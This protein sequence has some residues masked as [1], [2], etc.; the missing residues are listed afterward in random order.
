MAQ[1]SSDLVTCSVCLEVY[2]NPRI[3]PCLHTFCEEC[4][5]QLAQTAGGALACPECREVCDVKSI[6]HDFRMQQFLE[7]QGK[8]ELQE[9][10]I[11]DCGLC[12][13]REAVFW[14]GQCG[15]FICNTCK[16]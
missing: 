9:E 7:V 15:E 4:V 6:K 5:N 10:T 11:K 16:K 13:E 14:C 8:Q 3:L 1:N 12:D 2:T